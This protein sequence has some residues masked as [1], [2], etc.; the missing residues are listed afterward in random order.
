MPPRRPMVF[1]LPAT[2]VVALLLCS[3]WAHAQAPAAG[4][5]RCGSSYSD[6]PC[7]G[8]KPVAADDPRSAAQLQQAQDVKRRDAAL[9]DQLRSER[10]T[11]ERA[12]AAQRAAGIGPTAAG[13]P[14][15]A[16][17]KP[18]GKAKTAKLRKTPSQ[19]PKNTKAARAA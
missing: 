7:P 19:K 15:V 5:Y 2:S 1:G 6:A 12:A 8:G 10:L 17:S 11:R 18:S 3:T 13:A 4:V 9:A 16:A 14:K